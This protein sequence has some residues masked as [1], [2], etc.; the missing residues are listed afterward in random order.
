MKSRIIEVGKLDTVVKLCVVCLCMCVYFLY[1]Y[2][3]QS[4]FCVLLIFTVTDC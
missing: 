4:V 1:I 2:M 3:A